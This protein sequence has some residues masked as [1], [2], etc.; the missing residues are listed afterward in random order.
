MGEKRVE[1]NPRKEGMRVY[2]GKSRQGGCDE[3]R[4]ANPPEQ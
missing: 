2:I 1:T 4:R 3:N